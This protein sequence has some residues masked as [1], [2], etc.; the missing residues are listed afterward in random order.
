MSRISK[1]LTMVVSTVRLSQLLLCIRK[2]LGAMKGRI[3]G[4]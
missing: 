3:I 2:I 1:T 4:V